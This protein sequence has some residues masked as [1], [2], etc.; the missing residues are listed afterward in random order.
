MTKMNVLLRI[1]VA[2]EGMIP[3]AHPSK[4]FVVCLLTYECNSYWVVICAQIPRKD[5]VLPFAGHLFAVVLPMGS[6]A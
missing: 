2:H 1:K 3:L 5:C 6:S 4:T